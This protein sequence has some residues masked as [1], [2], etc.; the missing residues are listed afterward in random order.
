MRPCKMLHNGIILTAANV[1]F[2]PYIGLLL[3]CFLL[4]LSRLSS[5]APVSFGH[6]LIM[7]QALLEASILFVSVALS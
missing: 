6:H 7:Q 1:L 3:I 2:C 4:R 5:E